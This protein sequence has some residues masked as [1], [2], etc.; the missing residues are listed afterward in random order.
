[1]T[2]RWSSLF[3]MGVFLL[4]ILS[5]TSAMAFQKGIYLSQHT[6][7]NTKKMNY[8]IHK[9][10]QVGIN[11]FI[12]D[13]KK[14]GSRSYARNIKKARNNGI[15]I[16][17]RIVLF[18]GGGT[19]AQVTNKRI[20]AQKLR[21]AKYAVRLGAQE[22]QLD[23]IRYNIRSGSSKQKRHHVLNVIKYFRANLPS[24]IK[25][26]VDIFGV[27]AKKPSHTIG[28]DA[29]LFAPYVK[30]I[31]PMVYPS[32]YEP[33]RYH[34]KKPY[35]TVLTAVDALQRQLRNNSNVRVI[36]WI[37]TYNYRNPMSYAKR[38]S[39]TRSQMQ[40]ARDAGAQGFYVWSARNQYKVLFRAMAH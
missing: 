16:V 26:Q 22:I 27:V 20:W 24:R 35:K 11:T 7:Q 29:R 39:Y 13:T 1:M 17:S 37:E 21:L 25:L 6:V 31:A 18:P 28:Q 4:G 33:H 34:A 15:R 12:I 23:Y 32:H 10:K 14:T 36:P 38:I 9:A 30:V 5:V 40:A 3:I 19:H 8:F 2:L